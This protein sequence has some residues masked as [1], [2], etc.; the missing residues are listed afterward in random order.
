MEGH[1]VFLTQT[2]MKINNLKHLSMMN[3]IKIG[4]SGIWI[5]VL[6]ILLIFF[7][8]INPIV[9]QM[10]IYMMPDRD[11]ARRVHKFSHMANKDIPLNIQ[12]CENLMGDL[13]VV[14]PGLSN[15]GATKIIILDGHSEQ[16]FV[17]HLMKPSA[18]YIAGTLSPGCVLWGLD[19][20]FGGFVNLV[21]IQ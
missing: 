8:Y 13:S 15:R 16:T 14:V 5:Y 7:V 18:K 6:A 21:T 4:K 3:K 1:K 10:K 11:G 9:V 12:P 20:L 19:S 17:P 2:R